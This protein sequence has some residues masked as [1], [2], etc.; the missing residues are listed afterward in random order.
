MW[1]LPL[2]QVAGDMGLQTRCATPGAIENGNDANRRRVNVLAVI[3]VTHGY[4]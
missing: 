3:A 4:D 1:P 2:L